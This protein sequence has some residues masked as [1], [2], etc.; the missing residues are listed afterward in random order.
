MNGRVVGNP[1]QPKKLVKAKVK[2]QS[3]DIVLS[4]AF[5]PAGDQPIQRALPAR[6]AEDQF[7]A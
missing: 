4:P 7:L 5:R 2:K 1:L 6:D 3:D